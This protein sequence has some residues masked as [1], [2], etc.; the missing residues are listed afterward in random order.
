[1]PLRTLVIGA[2]ACALSVS[3]C[4]KVGDQ[5]SAGGTT[6][7]TGTIP[8]E[9]RVASQ[10]SPNTLNPLLSGFTTEGFINRLSF[11]TLVSV[12]GSGKNTVPIL[13]TEVPTEANGGISKDGLTIT[14]H[15]HSGVKWHDGV[16]FSSKDVKFSWQAMMN[17]AN[18]VNERVGYEEVKSVETPDANTVVFHLKRKFAPF[19][20]TVFAESDSPVCVVPEHILSK[21]HDI[22]RI[23]FNQQPI[24][25]GPFK[26]ARWVRGDHIEF[27]ANDDYFRG[28]PKL[29]RIIVREIP[30]ENTSINALRA[31][32]VDWIFEASPGVYKTL[33]A[34]P[35]KDV[36]LFLNS[37]PQT[38]QMLV[39]TSRPPLDDIRIRRALS[40]AIDKEA[41]VAKNTGGSAVVAWADQPP[42]QWSYTDDVMKY[43]ADTAK[44]R[45]L[46]AEAGYSPGPDGV[47]RKGGKPLSFTLSYNQENATRRLVA[48]QVQSMLKA[49][50]IDAQIK[51]YPTNLLFATYGQGGIL[52]NG[53][54]DLNISGW[55]AGQDPDDHSEFASDQIPKPSHPD[56]V[57][58]TRYQSKEMDVAQQQ[59]LASYDQAKRKP[60]YVKIQQLLARDLPIVYIWYPRQA[61]PISV[62]FKN[63]APNPVNESWN[64]HEWEI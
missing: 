10:R 9:L 1:M 21:F 61:Q 20:D 35:A 48:V 50:G 30:D 53:K 59:A 14:Y 27:V 23:P 57:N 7:A 5:T 44:A 8:G 42:F 37:Q 29:R 60:A 58:Y 3:A 56:G 31:H 38:L 33:K 32:D 24:G 16:P 26:V 28:K 45:A 54:Y 55:I 62:D 41:L 39:N 4:S 22:N 13:A 36:N 43:P 40:Y 49:A 2:L 64:A 46:L 6:R 34:N 52:T 18:N 11:D 63:F 15:L 17:P 25:T 12:D 51:T 19:V 47:M